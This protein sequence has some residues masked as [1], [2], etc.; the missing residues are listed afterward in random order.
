[1]IRDEFAVVGGVGNVD[2]HRGV[3]SIR[4]LH[5]RLVQ[6]ATQSAIRRWARVGEVFVFPAPK[7]MPRHLDVAAKQPFV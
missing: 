4:E 2:I 6:R 7:T 3:P 1:M 5:Q